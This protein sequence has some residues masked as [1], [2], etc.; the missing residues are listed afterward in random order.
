LECSIFNLGQRFMDLKKVI[1]GLLVL[2]VFIFSSFDLG[3]V[4][5][6]LYEIESSAFV[7]SPKPVK[8]DSLVMAYDQYLEHAV[9]S[10]KSPGAAVALVYKGEIILLKGYGVKQAGRKDSVNIHTVFRLGSCSKG[11]ASVLTGIMVEKGDLS[12]DDRVKHFLTDFTLKDTSA[13]NHLT[14]RNILSQTS[15]LPEHT[16]TD[17]LDHGYDFDAI[18]PSLSKVPLIAKPGQVYTYQNVVYSLIGDVL[19]QA[20]GEDYNNLL[21]DNIFKPLNMK[22]ASTDYTSFY[23][24]PNTAMPHLRMGAS[25]KV[26]PKNSRYYSVSPAS[27]VNA[28]A[29]DMAKWLLA[30]TGYYPE[31]LPEKTL[32]DISQHN[33]E[34][35]KKTG[36]KRNWKYLDKTYYGLGWRVFTVNG[37]DIVYHGGY[38]EG[39]RSEIAF[40]PETKIGIAVL[41]NS[42]TY[43]ASQCVP[44]FINNFMETCC[45]QIQTS[46]YANK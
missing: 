42:N 11:F 6:N 10:F 14:I 31:V 34:T 36:Y 24:N 5:D 17:M 18:K 25:W 45:P 37:H 1:I 46:L 30:L 33:I 28:S 32:E 22:D 15:G 2:F 21:Q 23:Y 4:S 35:P 26:K 41:F 39:F 12:W 8:L 3:S 13:S 9:D 19:F 20:T 40:D 27:G 29:S 44:Y 7:R 43:V 38:V 16:F